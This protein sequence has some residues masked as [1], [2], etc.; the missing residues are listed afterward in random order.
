[1]GGFADPDPCMW[2]TLDTDTWFCKWCRHVHCPDAVYAMP[3]EL[4]AAVPMRWTQP[5]L[6]PESRLRRWGSLSGWRERK[7]VAHEGRIG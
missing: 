3:R 2:V 6:R 1:M 5:P 4:A 7:R